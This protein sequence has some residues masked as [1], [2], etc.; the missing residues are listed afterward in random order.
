MIGQVREVRDRISPAAISNDEMMKTTETKEQKESNPK[1][2]RDEIQAIADPV[3]YSW[4]T[5]QPY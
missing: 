3:S 5:A 4:L 1:E 2:Q